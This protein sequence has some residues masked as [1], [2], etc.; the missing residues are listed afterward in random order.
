MTFGTETNDN[1]NVLFMTTGTQPVTEYKIKTHNYSRF[2]FSQETIYSRK[3]LKDLNWSFP[4][5][6]NENEKDSRETDG[7]I[8]RGIK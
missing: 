7:N 6:C 1:N 8:E 5:N 4:R 2:L 3:V